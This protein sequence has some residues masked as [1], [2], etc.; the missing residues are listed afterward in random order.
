MPC[1]SQHLVFASSLSARSQ[2]LN[3]HLKVLQQTVILC[4]CPALSVVYFLKHFPYSKAFS[5][6]RLLKWLRECGQK[7]NWRSREQNTNSD[8]IAYDLMKTLK[9][10]SE[11]GRGRISQSQ[12]RLRQSSFYWIIR[13]GFVNGIQGFWFFWLC[14]RRAYM[15]PVWF[16]IFTLS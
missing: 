9:W 10:E 1:L 12:C 16:S 7:S 2:Y 6:H 11:A 15:T 4:R 5:P 3:S 8:S 14:F 13:N